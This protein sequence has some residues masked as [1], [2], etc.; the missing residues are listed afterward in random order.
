MK[1]AA[2][3]PPWSPLLRSNPWRSVFRNPTGQ[4]LLPGFSNLFPGCSPRRM[5]GL[6]KLSGGPKKWT[7]ILPSA[8]LTKSSS[9]PWGAL[10]EGDLPSSRGAGRQADLGSLGI[11]SRGSACRPL[12]RVPLGDDCESIGGSASLP[13]LGGS[14]KASQYTRVPLSHSL[15]G[16][17]VGDSC[18]RG[19]PPSPRPP[20]RLEAAVS[21]PRHPR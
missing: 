14:R 16:E 1:G 6:P 21:L 3:L 13:A 12:L 20:L 7:G 5:R 2:I 11:R 8:S 9:R 18:H 15:R 10:R 19:A 17:A 4:G